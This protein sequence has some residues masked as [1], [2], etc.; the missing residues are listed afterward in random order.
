MKQ[1]DPASNRHDELE[2]DVRD[3]RMFRFWAEG[4]ILFKIGPSR[5]N[6][7]QYTKRVSRSGPNGSRFVKPPVSISIAMRLDAMG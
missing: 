2:K 6:T 4:C 3:I 7:I 5:L 1:G